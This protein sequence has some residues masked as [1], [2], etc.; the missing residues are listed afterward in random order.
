MDNIIQ[1]V[2]T[3][4]PNLG[5]AVWMLWQQQQTIK[6]MLDNQTK[7]IDRLLN[8]VDKDKQVLQQTM[9]AAAAASSQNGSARDNLHV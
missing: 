4:L 2:I 5:V 1:T 6:A 9:S 7:L 3:Q 8:Y